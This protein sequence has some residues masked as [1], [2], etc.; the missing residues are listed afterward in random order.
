MFNGDFNYKSNSAYVIFLKLT[1]KNGRSNGKN[2]TL[3]KVKVLKF[4][5][6]TLVNMAWEK[7]CSW[8]MIWGFLGV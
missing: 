8:G 6:Q 2:K 1:V 7:F 5:R 4:L 3:K